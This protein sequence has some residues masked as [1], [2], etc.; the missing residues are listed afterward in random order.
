MRRVEAPY[1][2]NHYALTDV[3]YW[4]VLCVDEPQ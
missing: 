1:F 2:L 3:W 4:E